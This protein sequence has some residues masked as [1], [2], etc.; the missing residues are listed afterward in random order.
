MVDAP[1]LLARPN[2]LD[3]GE[4]A[5]FFSEFANQLTVGGQDTKGQFGFVVGQIGNVRQIRVGHH[6]GHTHHHQQAKQGRSD[7]ARSPNGQLNEPAPQT[8]GGF[9][10]AGL[11]GRV[12]VGG[13]VGHEKLEACPAGCRTVR[14]IKISDE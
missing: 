12:L 9:E 4:V 14:I 1:W 11:G 2:V 10:Q 7:Q 5:A 6:H 8:L 13:G 3:G